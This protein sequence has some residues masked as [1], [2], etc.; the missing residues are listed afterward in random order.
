ML[1]SFGE[2]RSLSQDNISSYT[3]YIASGKMCVLLASTLTFALTHLFMAKCY[4]SKSLTQMP[5]PKSH[6]VLRMSVEV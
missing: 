3:V 5:S 4:Y 1:F 2:K 6:A